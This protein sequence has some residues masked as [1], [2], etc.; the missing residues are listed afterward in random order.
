M[1]YKTSVSLFVFI[2]AFSLIGNVFSNS[3]FQK[4]IETILCQY[5]A[6][7]KVPLDRFTCPI[8]NTKVDCTR[9]LMNAGC[10][11]NLGDP[12]E[13]FLERLRAGLKVIF[14]DS[15]CGLPESGI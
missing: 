7:E 4:H 13:T 12:K 3:C 6:E 2:I 14:P 9:N 5:R 15:Q 1:S 10:F 8:I 11:D